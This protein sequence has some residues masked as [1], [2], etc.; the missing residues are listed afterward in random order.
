MTYKDNKF[1]IVL[2]TVKLTPIIIPVIEKLEPYFAAANHVAYVVSGERDA[3]R[4]M[5]IIRDYAIAKGIA[6]NFPAAMTC[7]ID[8]KTTFN[9]EE[10]YVWQPL[11]STLNSLGLV[12]NP[13]RPAKVLF[14]YPY[15][16]GNGEFTNLKGKVMPA[17]NHI[18]IPGVNKM[19]MD[20]DGGSNGID[21]E[22]KI[23]KGAMPFIP[24][25]TAIVSE[26][27]NNCLHLN[28]KLL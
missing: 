20:I 8:D 24:Q 27:N 17:S 23:V 18:A 21:D 5:K 7:G 16:L 28:C 13:P 12:I 14:D 1:L 19:A 2:P 4:Q 9:G 25:I 22:T 3:G 11:L 26:R 15:P 10:V 6:K